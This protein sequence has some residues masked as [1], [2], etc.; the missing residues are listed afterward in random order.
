M[1]LRKLLTV[2]P[3]VVALVL[4]P[5][6][7]LAQGTDSRPRVSVG[8]GAGVAFPFHADFDFTPWA[9]EADLRV[10]MASHVL[11]EGAVGE[12]RHEDA[13]TRQNIQPTPGGGVIG[14]L[15]QKTTRVQRTLQVNV[16]FTGA[17]GRV[18]ATA[19]GGVG[20]LQHHRTTSSVTTDCSP[21]VPCGSFES[22]FSSTSG[23]AQ[24]VGGAEVRLGGGVAL[25]GQVRFVVPF[26]DPS[27][28]DLRATTGLRFGFGG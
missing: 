1:N 24:A 25:Y 10:A 17:R 2:A 13:F 23:S 15:E 8:A 21:G 18:R 4:L 11:L 26:T 7:A 12:W 9:W 6:F 20:L 14:R 27:G 22:S 3:F 19:G 16:L 5:R 28:G